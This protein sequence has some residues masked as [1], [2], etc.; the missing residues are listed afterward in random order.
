MDLTYGFDLLAFHCLVHA[1]LLLV[2]KLSMTL[3][4]LL[5]LI[6]LLGKR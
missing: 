3:M 6:E 4:P 5:L 2:E 1:L